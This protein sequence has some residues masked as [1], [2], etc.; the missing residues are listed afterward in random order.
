MAG[1]RRGRVVPA[2]CLAAAM[3]TPAQGLAQSG[4]SLRHGDRLRIIFA[5]PDTPSR[6][7]AVYLRT[8]QDSLFVREPTGTSRGLSWSSIKDIERFAGRRGHGGAGARIGAVAGLAAG[9][10]S[11][12]TAKRESQFVT[13]S[14]AGAVL[15]A[16]L[17][18][19]AGAGLG[20]VIGST[21]RSDR[22]ETISVDSLRSTGTD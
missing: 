16:A 18:T 2:V 13:I 20:A 6:L 7:E 11:G 17:V 22:W 4:T 9:I 14:A 8:G 3:A 19:G 21:V 12:A 15:I 1:L 10:L 5:V